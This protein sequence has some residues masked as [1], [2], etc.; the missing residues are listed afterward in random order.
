MS[1]REIDAL[2][3]ILTDPENLSRTADEVAILILDKVNLFRAEE[4]RRVADEVIEAVEGDRAEGIPRRIL[5]AIDDKRSTTHRIAVVGQI[6][7][8][9]APGIHTVVLGPFTARGYVDSPEKFIRATTGET[10]SRDAGQGLAWDSKTKRGRGRFMLVPVLR[11]ARDA[12]DFYRGEA[13]APEIA[14][15]ATEWKP[16]EIE[17]ICTCGLPHGL[18]CRFCGTDMERH[19]F[20]HEPAA[21]VHRCKK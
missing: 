13:P 20:R 7:Y 10:A 12:W 16:R 15:V 8:D 2:A 6:Q 19:C 3:S 14:Q 5:D 11:S 21:E 9:E 1:K 18:T 17:P 4:V